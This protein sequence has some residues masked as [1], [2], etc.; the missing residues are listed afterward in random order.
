MP[1]YIASSFSCI[2]SSSWITQIEL[3]CF[4]SCAVVSWKYQEA[5]K[6]QFLAVIAEKRV[7]HVI[8]LQ[9]ECSRS[10][11]TAHV[12][13]LQQYRAVLTE[14]RSENFTKRQETTGTVSST[15]PRKTPCSPDTAVAW[16]EHVICRSAGRCWPGSGSSMDSLRWEGSL[17]EIGAQGPHWPRL[18]SWLDAVLPYQASQLSWCCWGFSCL[19]TRFLQ[20]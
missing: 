5:L 18:E 10:S 15:A 3:R 2:S 4:C 8:S 11:S 7:L 20:I 16:A 19:E 12:P 1:N 13:C 14:Q 9:Q 6:S 17:D